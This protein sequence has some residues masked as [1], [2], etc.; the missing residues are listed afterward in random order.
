ML[1]RFYKL[2]RERETRTFFFIIGCLLF[3]WPL[4]GIFLERS[5]L[6]GLKSLF[7]VWGF[8]IF[9]LFL[10]SRGCTSNPPQENDRTQKD[11]Q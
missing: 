5:L 11:R 6:T 10:I 2:L 7:I 9:I 1:H 8:V 4:M 3:N